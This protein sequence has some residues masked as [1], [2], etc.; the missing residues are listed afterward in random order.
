MGPADPHVGEGAGASPASRTPAGDC[1]S[2]SRELPN[3]EMPPFD[4]IGANEYIVDVTHD[5]VRFHLGVRHAVPARA[6]HLVP[7]AQLRLPHAAGRRDRLPLHHRRARGRRPLVRAAAR[8][9][10]LRRVVRRAARRPIVR[11]GRPRPLDGLRR[12]WTAASARGDGD[13]ALDGPAPAH[14]HGARGLS[15]AGA[16]ARNRRAGSGRAG[17]TGRP[18]TRGSPARATSTSRRSSTAAPAAAQRIRPTDRCRTCGSTCRSSAAAGWRSASTAART[19]IRSSY[20]GGRPVRASRQ[21]AAW[22]LEAV[23]QCWSQKGP[24]IRS[25]ERDAAARAYDH[26]R[27]RYRAILA[28]S[29]TE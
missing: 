18:S 17:L 2:K 8:R 21:S 4:G 7:H 23:D 28:E 26:A 15:A 20:R 16:R 3:Y 6:Q 27:Q 12:Q 19:P 9:A 24:R 5:A 22:C 14:A 10:D 13:L 1:R 11:L 25:R 29:N